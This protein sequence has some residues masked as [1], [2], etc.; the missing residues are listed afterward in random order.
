MSDKNRVC[1][2]QMH[3]RNAIKLTINKSECA[4]E[5]VPSNSTKLF[6]NLIPDMW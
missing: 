5:L 6:P 4:A 3:Y 1:N 2:D